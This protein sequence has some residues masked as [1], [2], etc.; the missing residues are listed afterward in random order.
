VIGLDTDV[1]VR[2]LAQDD[3]EQAAAATTLV[4]SLSAA[5]PG[6]VSLVTVVELSWVL[7]RAYGV[8]AD[9]SD[10]LIGALLDAGE[11][12]MDRP[13]VVRAALASHGR[14]DLADAVIA[15][16]G[17]AAG[18]EQTV[19]FDRRAARDAGMTLVPSGPRS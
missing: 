5:D 8:D 2:Y 11:L 12:R 4:E 10:E 18:C 1:L 19:T 15:E 9:R 17:R 16:L 3:P 13:S 14:A 6:F 7:R